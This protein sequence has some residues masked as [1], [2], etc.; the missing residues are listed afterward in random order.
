VLFATGVLLL[1]VATV[2]EHR[3]PMRTLFDRAGGGLFYLGLQSAIFF[4]ALV[5]SAIS[6]WRGST[7]DR[8]LVSVP[9]ALMLFYFAL[10]LAGP[11]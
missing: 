11:G 8:L 10:F 6:M 5:F 1:F 3:E 2:F 9:A 4:A 7:R